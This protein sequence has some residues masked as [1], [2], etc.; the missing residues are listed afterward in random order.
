MGRRRAVDARGSRPRRPLRQ[1]RAHG[2]A[3]AGPS[4][5][6]CSPRLPSAG[7][8]QRC[9]S[10][11]APRTA[12]TS[13]S[14]FLAEVTP[15]LVAVAVH[16]GISAP[17]ITWVAPMIAMRWPCT[18]TR[19]GAYASAASAPMPTT[20]NPDVWI[21]ARESARPTAP[22][23]MPWL[24]AIVATSTPAACSSL[25]CRRRRPE[26]V[27]LR[28]G[29]TRS[30]IAG[31]EVHHRDVGSTQ[32]RRWRRGHAFG[33]AAN[34]ALST[35][36]KWTSPP[37]ASVTDP[38]DR[39]HGRRGRRGRCRGRLDAISRPWHRRRRSGDGARI[40]GP[41]EHACAQRREHRL[42]RT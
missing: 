21:A 5:D 13:R 23:S 29:N 1:A 19:C 3:T 42:L 9:R 34:F 32:H 4:S 24:L 14:T 12:A 2:R 20:G 16:V 38:R 10:R 31:L 37:N 30:V 27:L 11:C 28:L 22:K 41:P 39:T 33:S 36:S 18:V 25:E 40:G 15:P 17:S 8:R 7:T 6:R 35:P 26:R